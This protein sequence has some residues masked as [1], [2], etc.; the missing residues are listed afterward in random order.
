MSAARPD[1][2]WR[3]VSGQEEGQKMKDGQKRD[4]CDHI[5]VLLI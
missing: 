4:S 5:L 1:A 3:H 2:Y